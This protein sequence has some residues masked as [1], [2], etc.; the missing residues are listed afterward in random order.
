MKITINK[1][2]RKGKTPMSEYIDDPIATI[3]TTI[4]ILHVAYV[5][6]EGII[7][8]VCTKSINTTYGGVISGGWAIL[9]LA[10]I[11][12]NAVM[13]SVIIGNMGNRL[14]GYRVALTLSNV[15]GYILI[16]LLNILL[17]RSDKNRFYQCC[18]RR[19]AKKMIRAE[20]RL[21]CSIMTRI[22]LIFTIFSLG[23]VFVLTDTSDY[24]RDS[25]GNIYRVRDDLDL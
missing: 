19:L 24:V 13:L 14:A 4:V 1:I 22:S 23:T 9:R 6:I 18:D 3:M 17:Y 12:C 10:R 21:G 7:G 11:L 5:W 2:F 16:I 15:I 20:R 25:S 8:M